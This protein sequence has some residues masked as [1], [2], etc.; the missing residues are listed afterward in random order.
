MNI[1][2]KKN[3]QIYF[4]NPKLD[5]PLILEPNISNI[6]YL[7]FAFSYDLNNLEIIKI[8]ILFQSENYFEL[9]NY[10]QNYDDKRL[11]DVIN[12]EFE[13]NIIKINTLEYK[14]KIFS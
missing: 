11:L 13:N 8:Q 4:T 12:N 14:E 5:F 7:F 9:I 2:C 3:N 1:I 6:Y 10:H